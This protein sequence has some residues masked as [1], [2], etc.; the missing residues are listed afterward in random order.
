MQN[1]H[2]RIRKVKPPVT[3]KPEELTTKNLRNAN[4]ND[5]ET[6]KQSDN[7]EPPKTPAEDE[8]KAQDEPEAQDESD[9]EP[10]F[11]EQFIE[12]I[13]TYLPEAAVDTIKKVVAHLTD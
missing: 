9:K 12:T 3:K 7:T 13:E 5:E 8:P 6:D 4:D 10:T 2:L 1:L 11:Y